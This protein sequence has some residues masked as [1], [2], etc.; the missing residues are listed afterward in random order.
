MGSVLLILVLVIV[1][2]FYWRNKTQKLTTDVAGDVNVGVLP[3]LETG[4]I[5]PLES[6]QSANPYDKANPFS[7]VKTNPF[8]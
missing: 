2:Y 8:E 5:N 4:A 6:A 1:G 7:E 3:A